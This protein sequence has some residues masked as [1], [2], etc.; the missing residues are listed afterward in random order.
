MRIVQP[1][2]GERA[3]ADTGRRLRLQLPISNA[4]M[5]KITEIGAWQLDRYV[6]NQSNG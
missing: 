5:L 3:V 2:R 4:P 1:E 6:F